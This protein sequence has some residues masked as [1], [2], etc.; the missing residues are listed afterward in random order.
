MSRLTE[1]KPEF[2]EFMPHT[3]EHGILY[4]SKRFG[5]AIHLC[6]CGC[7][8]ETVTP[9]DGLL[10]W[11]LTENDGKVTLHP[12]IGNQNFECRSHYWIRNNRVIWL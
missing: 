12:S 2:V 1:L 7:G 10:A 9:I 4:I 6:A 8:Y 11:K 5:L 3:K